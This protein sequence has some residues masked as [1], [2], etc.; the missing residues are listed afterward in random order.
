MA[1][2][3]YLQFATMP[4]LDTLLQALNADEFG[5][6]ILIQEILKMDDWMIVITWE[7]LC[8]GVF[9]VLVSLQIAAGCWMT[10]MV[11]VISR[12]LRVW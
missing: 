7:Y 11:H 6:T 10:I 9:V 2:C 8:P 4:M 12:C 3:N 5:W 1:L